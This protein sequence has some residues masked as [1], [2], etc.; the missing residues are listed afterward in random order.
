MNAVLVEHAPSQCGLSGILE[1]QLLFVGGKGGV[2]KTTLAAAIALAIAAQHPE[3]KVLLLSTDPAHS[4][5][6]ALGD[7]LSWP[8]RFLN[9]KVLELQSERVFGEFRERHR[10]GLRKIALRGTF[11]DESDLQHFL[12]AGLPGLDELAALK[13]I[14]ETVSSGGVDHLI[15]DTAPTGHTLR[16]LALPEVIRQWREALDALMAKHRLMAALYA[17]RCPADESDALIAELRETH[18]L[19]RET[20]SDAKRAAFVVVM[21][22]DPLSLWETR[23]LCGALGKLGVT[24]PCVLLN[25][26]R[27][28]NEAC[29]VCTQL[30]DKEAEWVRKARHELRCMFMEVPRLPY[31]PRGSQA[32]LALGEFLIAGH[33]R[34]W[35]LRASE[36]RVRTAALKQAPQAPFSPRLAKAPM[37]LVCGKGGVGKTTVASALALRLAQEPGT[38]VLLFSTDPAHSLSDAFGRQFGPDPVQ[39]VAGLDAIEVDPANRLGLLR[40][41][42]RRETTEFFASLFK[43]ELL[44]STLDREAMERLIDLSPPGLDEIMALAEL[45]RY[46]TQRRYDKFVVDTPPTGHFLRFLEMPGLMR[47]WLRAFFEIFLKYKALARVPKIQALLVNLSKDIKAFQALMG[48]GETVVLPVAIPTALAFEQT[49]ELLGRIGQL[50]LPAGVGV[51]NRLTLRSNGCAGCGARLTESRKFLV[52]YREAYPKLHFLCL[53]EQVENLTGLA[54]LGRISQA[55]FA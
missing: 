12:D 36:H 26:V 47:A 51:L 32:L 48:N 28:R 20:I 24:V 40:E 35:V 8:S 25:N 46:I 52:R 15:V 13:V 54:Q 6:H 42:Y 34:I 38:R 21:N 43:S 31:E 30:C 53:E 9:L 39:V 41:T 4:V 18:T 1:K 22:P 44:D 19:F 55:L 50:A 29:P 14:A 11:L 5:G 10:E 27:P 33:R 49:H 3:R 2:G 17:G 7:A 16:L 23:R 45:S 37:I